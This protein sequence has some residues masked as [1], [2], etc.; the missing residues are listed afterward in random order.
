M[1]GV[2]LKLYE[3]LMPFL[4]GCF[5]RCCFLLSLLHSSAVCSRVI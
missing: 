5:L 2:L 4:A 1:R 3:L